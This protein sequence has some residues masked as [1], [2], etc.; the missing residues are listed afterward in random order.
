MTQSTSKNIKAIIWDLDGTLYQFNDVHTYECNAGAA[1]AAIAMGAGIEFDEA[2]ALAQEGFLKYHN[3]FQ[4]FQ[5]KFG[6]DAH[7]FQQRHMSAVDIHAVHLCEL[8]PV[9]LPTIKGVT[10]AVFT[11]G[12]KMW[13][14]RILAKVGIRDVFN[15]N[16]F[17]LECVHYNKKNETAKGFE[18]ILDKLGVKPEEAIM[19]EDS[20][21]NLVYPKK[22]GMTTVFI[23]SGRNA[24]YGSNDDV[25]DYVF[26][27]SADFLTA[28]KDGQVG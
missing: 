5:E 10:H 22:I 8:L 15:D 7:E 18:M 9:L 14:G 23:S 28:F 17:G 13:A 27:W 3:G 4:I 12:S 21:A 6:L 1:K 25:A 20:R 11:H 19:V 2:C 24:L 26:D 16:V